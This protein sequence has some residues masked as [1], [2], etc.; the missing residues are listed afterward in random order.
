MHAA[1][2][3]DENS[4]LH[5][6]LTLLEGAEMDETVFCTVF[7]RAWK[8]CVLAGGRLPVPC[9]EHGQSAVWLQLPRLPKRCMLIELWHANT[10]KHMRTHCAGTYDPCIDN[11]VTA[12]FNR[13][14]VQAA[15]HANQS[16]NALPYPWAGCSDTLQYS[17]CCQHSACCTSLP[18]LHLS[19]LA[20]GLPCFAGCDRSS[21]YRPDLV[22]VQVQADM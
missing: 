3:V 7:C 19:G 12:Y 21:C 5:T 4:C 17:R 8:R 13:P 16:W 11:E 22:E 10:C 9:L 6:E 20:R 18:V 2:V 1:E 14:D 15:M